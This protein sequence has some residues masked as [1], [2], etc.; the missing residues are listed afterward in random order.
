MSQE[1]KNSYDKEMWIKWL[2]IYLNR[3]YEELSSI[4]NDEESCMSKRTQMMNSNN[5]RQ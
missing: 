3:V 4:G 2:K 1:E 5:P